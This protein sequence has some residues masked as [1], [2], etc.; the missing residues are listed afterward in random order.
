MSTESVPPQARF[1]QWVQ[2]W[3]SLLLCHSLV[4]TGVFLGK[5]VGLVCFMMV[6]RWT[7]PRLRYDQI[8]VAAWQGLIPLT[9]VMVIVS[10]VMVYFGVT[11]T[12]YTATV[13]IA[14]GIVAAVVIGWTAPKIANKKIQLAGSRF[15]PLPGEIPV[16]RPMR[17]ATADAPHQSLSVPG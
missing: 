6:I 8:M 12:I 5:A 15:N 14:L 2:G 13:N 16:T 1:F 4:K 11:Q 3:A 7:I 17:A 9:L 10:S